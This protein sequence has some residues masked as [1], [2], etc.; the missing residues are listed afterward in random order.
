[1]KT[2]VLLIDCDLGFVFWLGRTLDRG[3]YEAFPAKSVPD[4]LKLITELNLTVGL[5]VLNYSLPGAENL[6]TTLRQ[7]QKYSKIILLVDDAAEQVQLDAD[8]KY[9]KPDGVDENSK[10]ELLQTIGRV[11]AHRARTG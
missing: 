7:S 5:V 4:A 1:V 2:A 3:G 10:A 9:R 6:I 8:A 11:L